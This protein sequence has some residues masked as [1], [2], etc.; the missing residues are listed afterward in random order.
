VAANANAWSPVVVAILFGQLL[1]PFAGLLSRHVKRV[2]GVLVFWAV[3]QLAFHLLD[4]YWIV[5]PEYPGKYGAL[6]LATSVAA[7]VGMGGVLLAVFVRGLLGQ[8]L[9]P[10]ADPRLPESLAFHNT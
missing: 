10:V 8:N 7:Y 9:R 6:A 2:A 5:M 4:T 3:W 1:I